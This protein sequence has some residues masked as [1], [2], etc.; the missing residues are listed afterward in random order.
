[1]APIM[2]FSN[3]P[4]SDDLYNPATKNQLGLWKNECPGQT[5][6]AY[7]G[8]SAKSYSI[9]I[10]GKAKN[11]CKGVK[12]NFAKTLQF[13]Q[14]KDCIDN[15]MQLRMN[16]YSIQSSNHIIRT[17]KMGKICLSSTDNKRFLTC[18]THSLAYGHFRIKEF[19]KTKICPFCQI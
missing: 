10:L 13:H 11:R 15:I 19:L 17:V 3:Y 6:E 16:Q 12:R 7:V 5:I 2:D 9:R 14:Y 18:P 8:L 4:P 1:M